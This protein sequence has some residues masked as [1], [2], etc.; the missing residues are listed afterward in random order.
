MYFHLFL[1]SVIG[2]RS[3]MKN[4]CNSVVI[5]KHLQASMRSPPEHLN[6]GAILRQQS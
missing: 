2:E 1:T 4:L 5:R 3:K 6:N